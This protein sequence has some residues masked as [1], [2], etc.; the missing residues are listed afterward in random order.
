MLSVLGITRHPPSCPPA[1]TEE[2]GLPVAA[3][4]LTI[5]FPLN[6]SPSSLRGAPSFAKRLSYCKKQPLWNCVST[7]V[8]SREQGGSGEREIQYLAKSTGKSARVIKPGQ[9]T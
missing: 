4:T 1:L 6:F 2:P 8:Q 3:Q 7:H 9:G 5:T